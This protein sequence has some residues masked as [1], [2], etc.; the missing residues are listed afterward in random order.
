[1]EK[2]TVIIFQF[3]KGTIRTNYASAKNM[4]AMAFQFH[5]GTIRTWRQI[6]CA[7]R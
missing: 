5:K 2:G 3:H 4:I 6:Q 1:M 7:S